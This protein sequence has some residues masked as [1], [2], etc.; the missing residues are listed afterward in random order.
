[1]TLKCFSKSQRHRFPKRSGMRAF[2]H[3]LLQKLPSHSS[4]SFKNSSVT[5]DPP[6]NTS[7]TYHHRSFETRPPFSLLSSTIG[8]LKLNTHTHP[9]V[10]RVCVLQERDTV[11]TNQRQKGVVWGFKGNGAHNNEVCACMR[12]RRAVEN[13]HTES[14]TRNGLE[15]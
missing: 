1:M 11:R 10:W 5:I 15:Q 13:T 6:S 12:N 3:H 7:T 9:K 14:C 2:D 4:P 8:K